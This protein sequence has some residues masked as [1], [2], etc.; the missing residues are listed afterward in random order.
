MG[1]IALKDFR[2]Y[3]DNTKILQRQKEMWDIVNGEYAI[4]LTKGEAGLLFTL[5]HFITDK[6][7]TDTEL[8]NCYLKVYSKLEQMLNK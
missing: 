3:R 8:R 2:N 1:V 5:L 7:L 6:E 4:N